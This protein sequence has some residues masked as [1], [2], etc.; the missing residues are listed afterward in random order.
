VARHHILLRQALKVIGRD[1]VSVKALNTVRSDARLAGDPILCLGSVHDLLP[2]PSVAPDDQSN[3]SVLWVLKYPSNDEDLALLGKIREYIKDNS[4]QNHMIV[5]MEPAL[6]QVL[7]GLFDET[8]IL[9]T[10]D[11]DQLCQLISRAG[12]VFSMRY[13][14]AIFALLMDRRVVGASQSKLHELARK[15]GQSNGYLERSAEL[16]HEMWDKA[17]SC[18]QSQ[19]RELNCQFVTMLRELGWA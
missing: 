11:L 12:Q 14:G 7:I 17:M 8:P 15:L 2:A 4:H 18:S 19:L 13:H 6:D 9:L 16:S 3:D 10:E 1:E 5:G